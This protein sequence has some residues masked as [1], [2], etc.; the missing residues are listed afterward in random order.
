MFVK[1][2]LLLG[3]SNAQS[4]SPR[5]ARHSERLFLRLTTLL[6]VSITT[7]LALAVHDLGLVFQIVRDRQSLGPYFPLPKSIFG[8][9]V[10]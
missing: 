7:G 10:P 3:R 2:F 4:F 8:T 9:F 1:L 5:E 6:F